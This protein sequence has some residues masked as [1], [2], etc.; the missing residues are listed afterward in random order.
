MST[1]ND[2]PWHPPVGR[3][4]VRVITDLAEPNATPDCELCYRTEPGERLSYVEIARRSG[5]ATTP[6]AYYWNDRNATMHTVSPLGI[7]VTRRLATDGDLRHML[8]AWWTGSRMEDFLD[9]LVN[10]QQFGQR[11]DA[12]LDAAEI[13]RLRCIAAE[14]RQ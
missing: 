7:T 3:L 13:D 12:R 10:G 11:S 5:N 8:S 4:F 2:T 14:V 6:R 1:T 9:A